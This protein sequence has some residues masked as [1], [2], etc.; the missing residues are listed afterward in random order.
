MALP[1][2]KTSYGI[3]IKLKLRNAL[4]VF[5]P[6]ICEYSSLINT[7]KHLVPVDGIFKRIESCHLLPASYQPSVGSVH[8][9]LHIGFLCQC[10][11]TFIKCHG[12]GRCQIGLDPHTFLRSHKNLMSVDMGTEGN[13][14]FPDL[15]HACQ[16]K[17][18]KSAG[19]CQNRFV[20]GHELVQS[21]HL[22]YNLI[23]RSDMEMIGI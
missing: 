11:R 15:P 23:S 17:H 13:A 21:S 4:C 14:F 22:L 8:R 7:K 9:I 2:S 18:L 10:R 5:P 12:N 20:P 19:I 3:A 16:G 6:D 1:D